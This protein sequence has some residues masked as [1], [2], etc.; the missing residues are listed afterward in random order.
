MAKKTEDSSFVAQY[1]RAIENP[2]SVGFHRGM[3]ENY[4]YQPPKRGYDPNN[5]GF[6]VDVE[7][8]K[9]TQK[10]VQGRAGK[11]LTEAEERELRNSHIDEVKDVLKRWTPKVLATPPSDTKQAMALGM[12]YRGD[13]IGNI[14]KNPALR[15]A[16]YSGSDAEFQKAVNDYY[17]TKG[18]SRRAQSHNQFMGTQAVKPVWQEEGYQAKTSYGDGGTLKPANWEDLT[19]AEKAAMMKAAVTEGF[20][21]L[22]TIKAKYNE[23]AGGGHI[24][25]GTSEESQQ[26]KIGHGH[27][28]YDRDGNILRTSDGKP[29]LNYNVALPEVVITP[30][31]SKSPGERAILERYRRQQYDRIHGRG[32][33]DAKLDK[34]QTEFDRAKSQNQWH[35]SF[36]K[37]AL[38]YGQAAA[39]GVG[40]G[41]DVV[42][43][44]PIYSTL[45]GTATLQ[46]AQ[47][48]EEYV[49]SG[50]WLAPMLGKIG[51]VGAQT[52]YNVGKE[53]YDS[54]ALWDKYTTFQGRFG[55]YGDNLL[56]KYVRNIQ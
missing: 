50:L 48:P 42:S 7:H 14:L 2:D 26:M 52:T 19:L 5:R 54:G 20:Y 16:F 9:K 37:K 18:L 47:T 53:L 34:E 24:Y 27:Y 25:D 10:V 55:N 8:N 31:S 1:I 30:D 35:N 29:I 22:P 12:L 49:E 38:D 40:I 45:K 17:E 46:R 15:D 21:D 33:Y 3:V 39:M 4:W 44:L 6:G 56:T 32:T 36:Q 28:S 11:W 51:K 23:F 13:G 43:G 41:A